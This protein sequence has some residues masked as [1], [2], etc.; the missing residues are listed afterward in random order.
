MDEFRIAVKGLI[1][2]QGKALL[3]K[4]RKDDVHKPDSWDIPGGRLEIGEDPFEGLKREIAE[5]AG[6]DIDVVMPIEVNHFVRDDGQKITMIIFLCKPKGL[7]IKLSNE[8]Q[9]Y[10]WADT[11]AEK[12]IFPD[13]LGKVLENLSKIR[14]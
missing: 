1:V 5:E 7:E 10:V 11:V 13:W 4:R 2:E 12:E 6:I 3:L 8:H 9:E 14:N